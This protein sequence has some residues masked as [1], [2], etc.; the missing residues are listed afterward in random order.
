[1]LATPEIIKT[2]IQEAAVIRLTIPRSEMMKVFGPAVSE[3]MAALID[4]Y[5]PT[6]ST[7]LPTVTVQQQLQSSCV[8]VEGGQGVR[9]SVA[10][11]GNVTMDSR[12]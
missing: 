9:Q 11:L 12:V 5:C 3:L 6:L 2:N 7:P 10:E 1:M 4:V 8:P